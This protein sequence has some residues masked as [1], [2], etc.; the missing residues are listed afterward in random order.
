IQVGTSEIL[1][2]D[3][4]NLAENAKKAG[5]GVKL[6]VWDDLFH[7]FAAFPSPESQQATEKIKDFIKKVF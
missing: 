6:D 7:V 5:V 4:L 3:S 2:D 1:L